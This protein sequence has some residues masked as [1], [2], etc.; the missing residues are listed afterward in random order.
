MEVDGWVVDLT[1]HDTYY[2]NKKRE[3]KRKLVEAHPDRG[4]SPRLFRA[5]ERRRKAWQAEEWVYYLELGVDPPDGK[6]PPEEFLKKWKSKGRRMG[7]LLG[8]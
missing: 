6:K 8:R 1:V 7:R 2:L 3:W 4:G 5:T